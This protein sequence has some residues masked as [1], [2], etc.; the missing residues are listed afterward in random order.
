ML[1]LMTLLHLL[2]QQYCRTAAKQTTETRFLDAVDRLSAPG[3]LLVGN[4]WGKEYF[5]WGL[6]AC[7]R[8]PV[9]T[10]T[11]GARAR[12]RRCSCGT[13]RRCTLGTKWDKAALGGF[14]TPKEPAIVGPWRMELFVKKVRDDTEAAAGEEATAEAMAKPW[15]AVLPSCSSC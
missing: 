1:R 5:Q 3:S 9:P 6:P 10:V 2:L 14:K 15:P 8:R 11:G 12:R 4:R 13:T 7:R